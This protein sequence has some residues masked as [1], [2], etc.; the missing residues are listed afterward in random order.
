MIPKDY[1]QKIRDKSDQAIPEIS[2]PADVLREWADELLRYRDMVSRD[3]AIE[4]DPRD[5]ARGKTDA[6]ALMSSI[7]NT[8]EKYRGREFAQ[9]EKSVTMLEQMFL[10]V[11]KGDIR[12]AKSI[13]GNLDGGWSSVLA[14]G[15]QELHN[16]VEA[17][18]LT[19]DYHQEENTTNLECHRCDTKLSVDGSYEDK[20]YHSCNVF[21]NNHKP[22]NDGRK[23]LIPDNYS[24]NLENFKPEN[25]NDE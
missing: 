15:T 8:A 3:P 17:G 4:R 12:R 18:W 13:I 24:Y 1:L 5:G 6:Y 25:N 9:L 10:S 19:L 16:A 22:R 7:K 11:F 20:G 2:V 21:H 14:D 23:C